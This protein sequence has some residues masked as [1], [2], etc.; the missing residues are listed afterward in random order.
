MTESPPEES[1]F[2]F[3]AVLGAP[4]V[5]KSTL[6]N[7]LVGSKV[8]IV[9]PKV[10]TTRSRI[11][12]I[13]LHGGSQIV[14]VDTPGIFQPKRRLDRAMV[15]AAWQG[16][17]D[18]DIVCLLVDSERGVD[19]DAQR[20]V[21]GLKKDGRQAVL[22]LNKIDRVKRENLLALS[23]RLNEIGIFSDTFMLSA[24]NGDGVGDFLD[25]IA[26]R[27]PPG[28]WH[29]PEDQISDLPQRLLAA[30]VTREQLFHLTHQEVPYAVAVDTD[31]WETFRDGSVKIMQTI[32]VQRD[33]QKPIIL[34]KGG[35]LI[36]RVGAAARGE[37]TEML[38]CAVHLFLHVKVREKWSEDRSHFRAWGLDYNA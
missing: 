21:E 13:A 28:V 20:I 1:R 6:I 34:G 32:Y 7:R 5:G 24:L 23:A 9:S 4:N 37:L 14:L 16:A 25:F 33:S 8:T 17:S 26:G 18:A 22:V 3:V 11:L 30:E 15:A 35:S 38:G 2:G 29:Y 36:K 31:S 12:G 10:Q 27:V 19:A